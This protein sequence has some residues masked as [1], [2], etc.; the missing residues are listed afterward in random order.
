M[1]TKTGKQS[2][3]RGFAK[4]LLRFSGLDGADK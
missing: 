3:F 1:G 4:S 2:S